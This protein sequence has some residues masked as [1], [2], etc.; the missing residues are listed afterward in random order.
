MAKNSFFYFFAFFTLFLC[1][2]SCRATEE[3]KVYELKKGD[4]SVKITNYGATVLS[5]IL[6]DKNGNGRK[7]LISYI[8]MHWKF[9]IFYSINTHT[10]T[11]F[12]ENWMMLFLATTPLMTIRLVSLWFADLRFEV[13]ELLRDVELIYNGFTIKYLV[14]RFSKYIGFELWTPYFTFWICYYPFCKLT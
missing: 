11:P 7:L 5:V 14:N 4:F 2:N 3:V 9:H 1:K 6:P 12:K 8:F 10:V 13:Y